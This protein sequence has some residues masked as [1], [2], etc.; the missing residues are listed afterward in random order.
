MT[1]VWVRMTET[2]PVVVLLRPEWDAP[3]FGKHEN[4][5]LTCPMGLV[6]TN[7]WGQT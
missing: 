2:V 1:W 6:I 5:V 4:D 7:F 3:F